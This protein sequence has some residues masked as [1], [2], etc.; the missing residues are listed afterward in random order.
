MKYWI[1]AAFV[2]VLLVPAAQAAE[3]DWGV[4]AGWYTDVSEPFFGVEA[5]T[6][7]TGNFWFNPNIEWVFIDGGDLA[8]INADVHYD[9]DTGDENLLWAGLGVALAYE[10]LGDSDFNFGGNLFAGYGRQYGSLIPY[11]QLKYTR[12]DSGDDFVIAAGVRF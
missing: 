2:L 6:P 12:I 4:R 11:A 3:V 1:V 10:N 8:T 5:I 7:I 9:W